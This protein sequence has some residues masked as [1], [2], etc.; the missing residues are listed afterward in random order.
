MESDRTKLKISYISD[1]IFVVAASYLS[2]YAVA[3]FYLRKSAAAIIIAALTA[4]VSVCAYLFFISFK[5]SKK[6]AANTSD[7][8]LFRLQTAIASLPTEKR[9]YFALKTLEKTDKKY[10][11]SGDEIFI[12]DYKLVFAVKYPE[13]NPDDIFNAL[14]LNGANKIIIFALNYTETA[15]AFLKS[16]RGVKSID[17]AAVYPLISDDDELLGYGFTLKREKPDVLKSFFI[18]D[19]KKA[20]KTALYGLILLFT[21][22]FTIFPVWYIICG[23]AFLVYSVI[24]VLFAK[25]SL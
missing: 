6:I 13:T 4:A 7:E 15:R 3:I 25:R 18:F 20:R 2:A 21:S 23:A 1:L 12:D 24:Q 8:T 22:R 16:A 10:S 9:G 14:S 17:L 19:R 5:N 11:V